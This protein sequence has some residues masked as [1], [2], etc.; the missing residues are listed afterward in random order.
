MKLSI[1]LSVLIL[2]CKQVDVVACAIAAA[3]PGLGGRAP[4]P[5]GAPG[6]ASFQQVRRQSREAS[7]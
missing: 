2:R 7:W 1:L 6:V 3:Q 4:G 5:Q